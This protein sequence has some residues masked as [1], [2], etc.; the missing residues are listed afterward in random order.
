MNP[1]KIKKELKKWNEKNRD[2]AR[3]QGLKNYKKNTDAIKKRV[4]EYKL[5]NPEKKKAQHAVYNAIRSGKLKK[6]PCEVCGDLKVDAH[7][8]SYSPENW[9]NVVWLCR[10]HHKKRHKEMK[11]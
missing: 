5:K 7:H 2:K 6:K 3:A 8:E 1:E 9:L 4:A 11:N 10:L